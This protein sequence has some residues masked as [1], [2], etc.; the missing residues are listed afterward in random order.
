[1]VPRATRWE[2]NNIDWSNFTNKVESKMN[3][4]LDAPNLSLRISH[5]ND[6]YISLAT[7]YVRKTK[8]SSKFKPWMTLHVRRK[9]RTPNCLRWTIC[10]NKQEWINT[11][12]GVLRLSTRSRQKVGK[13]S[14]KT[15]CRI[16]TAKTCGKSFKV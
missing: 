8:P 3:N 14:F 2:C 5:F 13:I 4:F 10:Q 16:Q 9:F 7:T 12:H 6:I 15:H 1:M 11:C